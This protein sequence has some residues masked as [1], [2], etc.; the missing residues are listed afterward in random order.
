MRFVST[1]ATLSTLLLSATALSSSNYHNEETVMDYLAQDRFK[2]VYTDLAMER[3][4]TAQE[5]FD[6]LMRKLTELQQ[7]HDSVA[8]E[9]NTNLGMTNSCNNLNCDFFYYF[10]TCKEFGVHMDKICAEYF[11]GWLFQCSDYP[12]K[13]SISN[14]PSVCLGQFANQAL[15]V[16]SDPLPWFSNIVFGEPYKEVCQYN[17]YENYVRTATQLL[18]TCY[19]DVAASFPK[20][21][22]LYTFNALYG[23]NCAEN[24]AE[25]NCYDKL[26]NLLEVAP[27]PAPS[28]QPTPNNPG[29]PLYNYNCTNRADMKPYCLTFKSQGCCYANQIIIAEQTVT[30]PNETVTLPA[31]VSRYLNITCPEVSLSNSFCTNGTN[32]NTSILS[33][34]VQITASAPV[35]PNVY[36][37]TSAMY[38]Q[39]VI[40]EALQT[41]NTAVDFQIVT[42][43]NVE[44]T[45]Y[46]YSA[47]DGTQLTSDDGIAPEGWTD[48][49]NA[50]SGT[51]YF[52]VVQ[53]YLSAA[54]SQLNAQFLASPAFGQVVAGAYG[55]PV[56][57]DYSGANY[58]VAQRFDTAH[59]GAAGAAVPTLAM[60]VGA[61]VA[62]LVGMA[63][64]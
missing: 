41:Y 56:A 10:L 42:A 7:S 50:A 32:S 30:S 31:C 40:A 43:L 27:T 18:N 13:A 14:A 55:A 24:A 49:L 51:F 47:A 8:V 9:T 19:D 6:H 44:L 4:A 17:C 25:E 63:A 3:E 16:V 37:Q 35:L 58:Y 2:T 1:I 62:A 33:G 61:A 34:F 45:D 53:V 59:S 28:S 12:A 60:A 64:V 23:L 20:L 5:P 46:Y 38:L 52:N 48:Y 57:T 39:G 54:D 29:F 15:P 36:N 22:Q 11:V 26:L 21:L